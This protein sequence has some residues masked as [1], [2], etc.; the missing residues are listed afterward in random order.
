[1]YRGNVKSVILQLMKEGK[2]ATTKMFVLQ[3]KREFKKNIS[4]KIINSTG[5]F[6]SL[7]VKI[8]CGTKTQAKLI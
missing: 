5:Y 2:G 1:M 6:H 4:K 7:C 3:T 8:R